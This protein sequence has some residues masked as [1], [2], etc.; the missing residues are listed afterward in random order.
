VSS[1]GFGRKHIMNACESGYL[2]IALHDES[3]SLLKLLDPSAETAP[4]VGK[5]VFTALQMRKAGLSAS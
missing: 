4:A 3:Y 2:N 1:P 5:F